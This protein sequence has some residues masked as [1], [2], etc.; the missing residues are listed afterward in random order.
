M[1]RIMEFDY[2]GKHYSYHGKKLENA[3]NRL[4]VEG[5]PRKA[6]TAE[7]VVWGQASYDWKTMLEQR[8]P[9][10]P[11]LKDR[12]VGPEAAAREERLWV[13]KRKKK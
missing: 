10:P 7:L 3:L 5:G 13:P 8:I 1:V 6:S 4:T 9:T 2:A 12:P 11:E